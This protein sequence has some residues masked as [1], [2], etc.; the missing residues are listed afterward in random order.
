MP[1][2]AALPE[3]ADTRFCADPAGGSTQICASGELGC[4]VGK[5]P[6]PDAP[7]VCISVGVPWL[8]PPGFVVDGAA[9]PVPGALPPCIPDPADCGAEPWDV[10]PATGAVVYVDGA[11]AAGG[12]GSKAKPFAT[13]TKGIAAASGDQAVVAVAAGVYNEALQFGKPVSV[14][15]RCAAKVTVV[16]PPSLE[17]VK[18]VGGASANQVLLRGL[19][20]SGGKAGVWSLGSLKIRLERLWIHEV[21]SG[22]MVAQGSAARIEAV[23]TVVADTVRT[24]T[25]MGLGV[26]ASAGG[27]VVLTRVRSSTN[28][29]SG[30]LVMHA[31]SSME[32]TELLVD[33]T[34]GEAAGESGGFGAAAYK[35]GKLSL[36]SA[37]LSGNRFS[38]LEV[39]DAGSRAVAIGTVVDATRAQTLV[40]AGGYGASARLGG[41]L[42]LVG[43]RLTNNRSAGVVIADAATTALLRAVYVDGTRVQVSDNALGYGLAVNEGAVMEVSSVRVSGNRSSGAKVTHQGSRLTAKWL[44]VDGT[45]PDSIDKDGSGILAADGAKLVLKQVRLSGNKTAGLYLM[46]AGTQLEA[47]GL[48]VDHTSEAPGEK[49]SGRGMSIHDGASATVTD[50]RFSANQETGVYV[51]GAGSSLD[52]SKLIVDGTHG[53]PAEGVVGVGVTINW[54]ARARLSGIR[55]HANEFIGLHAQHAGTS[56]DVSE[57]LIDGTLADGETQLGGF[58]VAGELGAH[59]GLQGVRITTNFTAGLAIVDP[60]STASALGVLVDDTGPQPQK[61]DMGVGV[62]AGNGAQVVMLGSAVRGNRLAGIVSN[63]DQL[64]TTL[65]RAVGVTIDD[66]K[67]DGKGRFGVGVLALNGGRGAEIVASI[68]RRNIGAGVFES[69]SRLLM[70]GSVV[71]DTL[72]GQF[73]KVVGDVLGDD[74]TK[75]S[76][77]VMAL[78]SDDVLIEGCFVHHQTRAGVLLSKV[79]S[80]AVRAS[81]VSDGLFGLATDGVE[82]LQSSNNLFWGN[83]T[84]QSDQSGLAVPAAPQLVMGV[85]AP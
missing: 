23:D 47:E 33:G 76:D 73:A 19:T 6:D 2:L 34:L 11:A 15:G 20:L 66:Q 79:V 51:G 64:A 9:A 12:D 17:V 63:G 16:A 78:N 37:R 46:D 22:G 13:I 28:A 62:F 67:P 40:S 10:G 5:M 57:A 50:G 32:A 26:V 41:R 7:A 69:S 59:I 35:G 25:L 68:A 80:A 4:G 83:Q 75:Y 48:L 72:V 77:G 53:L 31:G 36:R 82:Q 55:L 60:D 85:D 21:A 70:Q 3:L 56:V 58:G 65:A 44:L 42:E 43:C 71:A 52:A 27:R 29:M 30:V 8:C 74:L 1:P 45:L 84:N 49:K 18:V 39:S 81:V 38:G 54:G 24:G 14:R 61:G